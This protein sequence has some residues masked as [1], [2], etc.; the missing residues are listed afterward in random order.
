MKLYDLYEATMSRADAY[1]ALQRYVQ[2]VKQQD[3]SSLYPA[4]KTHFPQAIFSGN[5]SRAVGLPSN[6]K[7]GE[8]LSNLLPTD[9]N[10]F[11][12]W[13]KSSEGLNNAVDDLFDGSPVVI[14]T[15]DGEGID[16]N[17]ILGTDHGHAQEQEIIAPSYPTISIDALMYDREEYPPTMFDEFIKYIKEH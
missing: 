11:Y 16:V 2:E 1:D 17:N 5:M 4:L 12:S 10:R 14:L 15:Q 6:I 8:E 13:S 3:F 9:P 7:R